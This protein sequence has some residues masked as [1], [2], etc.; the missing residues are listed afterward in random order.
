MKKTTNLVSKIYLLLAMVSIPL[1]TYGQ[2]VP[3]SSDVKVGDSTT[4]GELTK[5][6]Y[7]YLSGMIVILAILM[8]I[9][10]AYM[11]RTSSGD[12][13][14]VGRAKEIVYG[15]IAGLVAVAFAYIFFQIINPDI[16]N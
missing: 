7:E 6:F 5:R 10:A 14:K 15:A 9:I 4:L 1:T 2:G 8:T 16:F 11:Y 3:G 12:P 13:K